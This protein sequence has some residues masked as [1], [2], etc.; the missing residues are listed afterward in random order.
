MYFSRFWLIVIFSVR[1]ITMTIITFLVIHNAVSYT[2]FKIFYLFMH[3]ERVSPYW[4]GDM[5]HDFHWCCAALNCFYYCQMPHHSFWWQS[6]FRLFHV[7]LTHS[8][9]VMIMQW[10]S[11][12]E[13]S[14]MFVSFAIWVNVKKICIVIH[15]SE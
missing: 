15:W 10:Y 1:Y 4:T 7:A 14:V 9:C 6:V 2:A 8:L 12:Q 13:E 11:S 5:N 3:C